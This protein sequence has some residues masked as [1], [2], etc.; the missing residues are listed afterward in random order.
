MG[1]EEIKV[2]G[3]FNGETGEGR[4]KQQRGNYQWK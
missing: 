3:F 2:D 1:P 4:G